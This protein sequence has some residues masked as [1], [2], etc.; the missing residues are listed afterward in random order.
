MGVPSTQAY[1]LR[2]KDTTE[3]Q[4]E[5]ENSEVGE[6]ARETVKLRMFRD[7]VDAYGAGGRR[8]KK[9]GTVIPAESLRELPSLLTRKRSDL[10]GDLGFGFA[11]SAR[12]AAG[13]LLHEGSKHVVFAQNARKCLPI[14]PN[15]R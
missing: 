15:K 8:R 6:G 9:L 13:W 5:E 4:K 7:F 10:Y 12:F 3:R 11:R 14:S 2:S 1:L